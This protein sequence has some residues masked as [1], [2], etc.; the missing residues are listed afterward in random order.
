MTVLDGDILRVSV[1]FELGGGVQYQNIWHYIRDGT[2]PFSDQAH[3][4]AIEG[5]ME[6]IYNTID[7]LVPNDVSAQLSFVD[8]VEFNEIVDEWRVVENI[9]TFTMTFTSTDAT[10]PLPY[11]SAPFVVFKTQR[12]RTVGKK[13][14]FPFGEA[15]Q[16]ATVL[17]GGAVTAMVA[18]GVQALV[19]QTVGGDVTLTAGV[20]RTGIQTFLNFLVAVVN[21]VIGS[22]RRRRP[23]VGA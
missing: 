14:L 3:V 16:E 2:D 6:A 8:R 20:V 11:Q 22:Q 19:S 7:D 12:P 10:D 5:R 21:D 23:G 9:G 18:F 17:V 4:D 15:Q 1:N 13:F